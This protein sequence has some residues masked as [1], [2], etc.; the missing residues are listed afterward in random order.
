MY[1]NNDKNYNLQTDNPCVFKH[2][3]TIF[4]RNILFLRNKTKTTS[5]FAIA[6]DNGD[7]ALIEYDIAPAKEVKPASA[8]FSAG[9]NRHKV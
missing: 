3:R 1:K 7:F 6:F 5:H 8:D 9:V 2:K 4:S